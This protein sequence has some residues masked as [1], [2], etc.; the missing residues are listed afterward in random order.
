M[1]RIYIENAVERGQA[2]NEE[3]LMTVSLADTGSR[4]T[5]PATQRGHLITAVQSRCRAA[6]FGPLVPLRVCRSQPK[7]TSSFFYGKISHDSVL[8][9]IAHPLTRVEKNSN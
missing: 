2:E 6:V 9:A 7:E 5:F 3:V 4:I 1:N 8:R